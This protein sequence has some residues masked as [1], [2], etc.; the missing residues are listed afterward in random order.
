M[1]QNGLRVLVAAIQLIPH[2]IS[3][4]GGKAKVEQVEEEVLERVSR[5]FPDY[6]LFVEI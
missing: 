5:W 4:V 3:E 1:L 2:L 6:Y